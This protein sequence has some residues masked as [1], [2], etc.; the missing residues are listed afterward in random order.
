M[1]SEKLSIK[2][3]AVTGSLLWGGSVL[4]VGLINLAVPAYGRA[5]LWL[6]SS[7][8]PGY[9]A[10]PKLV[11]VLIGVGYALLDGAVGGALFGWLYNVFSSA[12][13]K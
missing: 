5:F 8:Y 2:G 3:L 6:V 9:H 11:S 1:K 7:I 10:E 12:E 13:K 4:F